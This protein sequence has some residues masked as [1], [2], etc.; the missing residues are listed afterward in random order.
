MSTTPPVAQS[1]AF[2]NKSASP[3]KLV[4]YSPY[5]IA[6]K[7]TSLQLIGHPHSHPNPPPHAFK[8]DIPPTD[9]KPLHD[10]E[11]IIATRHAKLDFELFRDGEPRMPSSEQCSRMLA[12]FPTSY[13]LE[14]LPP[15]ITIRCRSLPPKPWPVTIAGLPLFLTTDDKLSP[16]ET[17]IFSQGPKASIECSIQPWKTPDLA[18]FEGMFA[19][20]RHSNLNVDRIQWLGW[21]F[22]AIAPG[23]PPADWRKSLP[24]RVNGLLVGYSFEQQDS[25]EK[26][27]RRK[28]PTGR[29]PDDSH[30]AELRPGIMVASVDEHR[31]PA[32]DLVTT[33]GICFRSPSTSKHYIT[34]AKHG[35]PGGVGDFVMHPGRMGT[36]IAEVSKVFGE[37]DIALAELRVPQSRYSRSTFSTSDVT[38]SPFRNLLSL[39]G[40]GLRVGDLVNIDTAVNGRCEGNL[41]KIEARRIPDDEHSDMVEYAIGSFT[42]FGNGAD[43]LFDG[44]CGAAVWNDDYDVIG[45][46]RF[47]ESTP[48]GLC[49]CP[50]YSTLKDLGYIIA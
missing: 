29:E 24:S 37:T 50:S 36:C 16:M 39:Q 14:F 15:F 40:Q 20:L 33:S 27:V 28:L 12:L 10:E 34:V 3:L 48:A 25:E 18:A 7:S 45:Q 22:L 47:Q 32:T 41:I 4:R 19:L 44:S 38:V 1:A 31:S 17:G 23:Q 6:R 8:L 2:R 35:F 30:Y 5:K 13:A 42:Y 46:F 43:V 49:Y 26:A 11:E 21:S 9:D